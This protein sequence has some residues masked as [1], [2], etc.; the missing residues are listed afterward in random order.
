MRRD[1]N[2]SGNE[3]LD[4]L[5]RACDQ[6]ESFLRSFHAKRNPVMLP[7]SQSFPWYLDRSDVSAVVCVGLWRRCSVEN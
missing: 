5:Y 4:M 7:H 3:W 2:N 6:G 1:R